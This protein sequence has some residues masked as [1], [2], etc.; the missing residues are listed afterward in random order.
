MFFSDKERIIRTINRPVFIHSCHGARPE[1]YLP[2]AAWWVVHLVV[3]HLQQQHQD[4]G[5]S[6]DN[7]KSSQESH[8]LPPSPSS[9]MRRSLLGLNLLVKCTCSHSLANSCSKLTPDAHAALLLFWLL[10]R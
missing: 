2:D 3:E 7:E 10:A 1:P 4:Q 5:V 8:L 6:E 9:S